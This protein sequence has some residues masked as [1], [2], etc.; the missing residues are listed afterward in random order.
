MTAGLGWR[1]ERYLGN[2]RFVPREAV[3]MV[4]FRTKDAAE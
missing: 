1:G 4:T 3:K 2:S